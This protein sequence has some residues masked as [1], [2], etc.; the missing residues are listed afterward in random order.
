QQRVRRKVLRRRAEEC[1]ARARQGAKD[2]SA[3]VRG[4]ERGRAPGG[5]KSRLSLRFDQRD[6]R[7]GRKRRG[8]AGAPHA[9]TD[10]AKSE[11]VRTSPGDGGR[12]PCETIARTII[13]DKICAPTGQGGP[14]E[15]AG[16]RI[17]RCA[18]PCA[19]G[20]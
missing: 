6:A 8:D 10:P 14:Y 11:H 7:A 9:G 1:C 15:H 19:G 5:V 3:I 18:A 13:P 16:E 20:P 4:E 12:A 2:R 17:S